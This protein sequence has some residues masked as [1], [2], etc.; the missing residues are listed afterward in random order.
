MEIK[1]IRSCLMQAAGP[2]YTAWT[3]TGQSALSTG[4]NWLFIEIETSSGLLGVGEASGWPKVVATGVSDI[5]YLLEGEPVFETERIQQKLRVA[6]MGHGQTGVVSGGVLAA[7]DM[8]LWDIKGKALGCPVVDLIGGSV[9]K[10]VPYYVHVKDS[11]T[12]LAAVGRGVRTLKVGGTQSVVE[13]A[14]AVR[15]AVGPDVDLIVDLHGPAWLNGADALAVGRALEPLGLLFLE[16]PVAPDDRG[17]WKR[18]R[19]GLALP[20][21]SGER[22]GT[23]AEFERLMSDGFI[24]V[25]QPD[26]GRCGGITQLKKI[27]AIAEA[28]SILVAPH[29]GSLGPVAE[30]AALHF[31]S[32]IPNGLI[33]ERLEPDWEGK[34]R[35]ATPMLQASEGALLTPRA[36]GLGVSLDH[37]FV[38]AHPS[39]RNAALPSG[40]WNPGTEDQ[41]P[42]MQARTHRARLTSR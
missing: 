2:S 30:F 41:T 13:R 31:M 17:G 36:P 12:A 42:Y 5:A 4:R 19:D 6:L 38:E 8:A 11:E 37:A 22:L 3:G 18:V 28:R 10:S 25:V 32:S 1:Q 35:A 40:G 26:T 24:D 20:L 9:R 34:A 21:A 29:S 15:E 7:I 16:E 33:M 23:L 14:W 27:A 39:V